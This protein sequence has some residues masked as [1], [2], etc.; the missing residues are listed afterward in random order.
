MSTRVEDFFQ[1]NRGNMR[2][3]HNGGF[4]C[5]YLLKSK[6]VV[7]HNPKDTTGI[8]VREFFLMREIESFRISPAVY[9]FLRDDADSL[10]MLEYVGP[11]LD[12]IELAV[13]P[14]NEKCL[15]IEDMVNILLLLSQLGIVHRD[16]KPDNFCI[17]YLT[18]KTKIIDFGMSKKIEINGKMTIQDSLRQYMA[19]GTIDYCSDKCLNYQEPT[20]RDDWE[21]L[22]LVIA[23]I[24]GEEM[25][26]M[27]Y[28]IGQEMK[29]IEFR[30]RGMNF[31]LK[32]MANKEMYWNL[33]K[34]FRSLE[35]DG[36]PERECIFKI[37]DF[38]VFDYKKTR[39]RL[40]HRAKHYKSEILRGLPVITEKVNWV[41]NQPKNPSLNIKERKMDYKRSKTLTAK[42]KNIMSR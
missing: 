23:Y 14:N 41:V 33:I 1:T 38:P 29:M 32:D 7:K 21:S 2:H 28:E 22:V 31:Y 40:A 30:K 19:C 10:L 11:A 5:V 8:M 18:G 27:H 3:L 15:I 6:Y 26:L 35:F 12:E 34:Y 36:K 20:F 37:L 16:L 17:N 9:L 13:V 42:V 25:P 4:S 39:A 24:M